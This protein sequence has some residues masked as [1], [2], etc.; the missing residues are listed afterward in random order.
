[1]VQGLGNHEEEIREQPLEMHDKEPVVRDGWSRIERGKPSRGCLEH[2]DCLWRGGGGITIRLSMGVGAVGG[3]PS[4]ALA[5]PIPGF[6]V[7]LLGGW[8]AS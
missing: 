2:E 4:F 1:M 6:A 5:T 8:L 7:G 3:R